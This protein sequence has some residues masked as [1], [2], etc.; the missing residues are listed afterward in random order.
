MTSNSNITMPSASSMSLS[1]T[2]HSAPDISVSFTSG[3]AS[4]TPGIRKTMML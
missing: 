3:S 1:V 2:G 4:E